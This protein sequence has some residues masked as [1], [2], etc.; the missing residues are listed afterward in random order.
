MQ[1]SVQIVDDDSD[2]GDLLRGAL[3]K[4]G[5]SATTVTS[6]EASLAA[7]EHAPVDIVVTDIH[8]GAMSGIELC[9]QIR[10]KH[11]DTLAIVMTGT[12]D[13]QTAIAAIQAGAYDYITKPVDPDQLLSL[14][15]VWLYS[16]ET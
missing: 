11:P 5:F 8:M 13:L 14:M 1:G 4:R 12:S 6:A 10:Q 15:R 2:V 7:L 3:A 9:K 16:N